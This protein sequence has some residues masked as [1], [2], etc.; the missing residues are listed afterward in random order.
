MSIEAEEDALLWIAKEATGSL[1]DAYTLFDQVA[2]F[3]NGKIT[4]ADISEKL[5]LTGFDRIHQLV[6]LLSRGKSMESIDMVDSIL[7]DGVSAEQ[8][9]TDMT[10]FFRNLLLLQCGVRRQSVLGIN[11]ERYSPELVQAFSSDQLEYAVQ[12]F[13]SFYK[14]IRYSLNQRY[15]LELLVSRLSVLK[16]YIPYTSLIEQV[17]A[18]QKQFLREFSDGTEPQPGP[19][20]TPS[21]ERSGEAGGGTA[22]ETTFTSGTSGTYS[23][24]SDAAEESP[25]DTQPM[26]E[27]SAGTGNFPWDELISGLKKTKVALTSALSKVSRWSLDDD[28]LSIYFTNAFFAASVREEMMEITK[29]VEQLAGRKISVQI[30]IEKE[31]EK[32]RKEKILDEQVEMV[33]KVFKGEIIQGG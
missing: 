8:F 2:S 17:G 10:D 20:R 9:V 32:E 15:E 27:S 28:T 19:D 24:G 14:N 22:E 5:G 4:M 7:A 31:E 6:E 25:G 16:K 12:M 11:P 33:K 13:L 26:T 1:R 18:L 21:P 29:R 30:H 23:T 3:S